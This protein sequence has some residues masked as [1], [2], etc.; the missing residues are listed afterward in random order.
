LDEISNLE[1]LAML[2]HA[3]KVVIQNS[4]Y[5]S[6]LD[7]L[8][9]ADFGVNISRGFEM[10]IEKLPGLQDSDIGTILKAVGDVFLYDIGATIGGLLGRSL[11]KAAKEMQGKRTLSP[12]DV[13]TLLRTV[14]VTTKEIGGAKLGDKT[15]IDAL[16]PAVIA[17]SSAASNLREMMEQA[18]RAAGEGAKN[19][20][21]MVSRIG[22]SSY[23]GE[24]SVGKADPG[25]MFI[26]LFLN[27]WADTVSKPRK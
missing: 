3:G 22:R 2:E 20:T 4:Q 18:A 23:L 26:Y 15:L 25:A 12:R 16:E 24:R 8:G 19:T 21:M 10:V 11:Q 17:A 27:A 6:E 1:F 14:L 7:M 5:L 9:D 13:V